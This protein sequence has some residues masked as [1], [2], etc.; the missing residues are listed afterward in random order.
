MSP[1]AE[2]RRRRGFSSPHARQI[3]VPAP[4][5]WISAFLRGAPMTNEGRRG[6]LRVAGFRVR[7]RLPEWG[8]AR[9]FSASGSAARL[10]KLADE[11]RLR[12]ETSGWSSSRTAAR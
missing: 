5:E 10:K 8:K 12:A 1:A 11:G 3:V 2:R 9:R 6:L 4:G 7:K